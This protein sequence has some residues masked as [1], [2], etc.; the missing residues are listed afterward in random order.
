MKSSILPSFSSPLYK[1]RNSGCGFFSTRRLS[2]NA[3]SSKM[4]KFLFDAGLSNSQWILR[5]LLL[6]ILVFQEQSAGVKM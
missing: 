2:E 3:L 6:I 4:R 5:Q 1:T